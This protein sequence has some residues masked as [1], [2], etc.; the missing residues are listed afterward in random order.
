MSKKKEKERQCY[1]PRK[2]EKEKKKATAQTKRRRKKDK[3]ERKEKCNLL[4]CGERK[5]KKNNKD[6]LKNVHMGATYSP[7]SL[8]PILRIKHFDGFGEKTY[9]LYHLFSF[10]STQ[11][12]TLQK[13]FILIFSLKFF[14]YFISPLN[15]HTLNFYFFPVIFLC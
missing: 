8:L 13:G 10:L 14:V 4:P 11:L 9:E 1:C 15:K 2:K 3:K 5:K 12:N 6:N 7:L